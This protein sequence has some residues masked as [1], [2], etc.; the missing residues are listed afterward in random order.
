MIRFLLPWLLL[1]AS[2]AWAQGDR[3][4]F[5]QGGFSLQLIQ[6]TPDQTRAFFQARGF[7]LAASDQI[8]EACV[9]QAILRNEGEREL[10]VDLRRWRVLQDGREK[11]IPV[12]SSWRP[13]WEKLRESPA[14]QIAF[15]WALFPTQQRFFP[16]D[17]A[18]GMIPFG[19]APDRVFDLLLTWKEDQIPRQGRISGI[20]CPADPVILENADE[21]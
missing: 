15:R 13:R 20:R 11:P 18:W 10:T 12:A 8:A 3:W 5:R 4:G 14:A 16:G 7:S 21:T 6:R 17:Q 1:W 9:L 19:P 2:T